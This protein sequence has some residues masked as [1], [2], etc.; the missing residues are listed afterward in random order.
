MAN[1]AAMVKQLRAERDQVQGQLVKLNAALQAFVGV[2][3]G[4]TKRKSKRKKSTAARKKIG[5]TPRARL[6]KGRKTN[7]KM[8]K[9]KAPKTTTP[10]AKA[11]KS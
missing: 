4:S 11:Q 5:A 1:L 8:R 9:T 3:T 10:K 6:A 7:S 2:Y